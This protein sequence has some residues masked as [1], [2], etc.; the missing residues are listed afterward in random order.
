MIKMFKKKEKE[1][2]DSVQMSEEILRASNAI[3]DTNDNLQ[4]LA[5]QVLSLANHLK[6]LYDQVIEMED[7]L[8]KLERLAQERN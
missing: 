2:V 4:T 6:D 3:S 8:Q 7:R 5:N 1:Q